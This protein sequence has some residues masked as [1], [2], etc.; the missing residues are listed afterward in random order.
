MN[1]SVGTKNSFV[2]SWLSADRRLVVSA[3]RRLVV[4]SLSFLLSSY[5]SPHLFFVVSFFLLAS[6]ALP[7]CAAKSSAR[8]TL[9]LQ[10]FRNRNTYEETSTEEWSSAFPQPS[11]NAR[12]TLY[13]S[14]QTL[15][16]V[17]LMF[18]IYT[19]LLLLK[20]V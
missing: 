17:L 16:M 4:S 6:R 10:E 5:A 2:K 3:N 9:P 12:A 1:K 13:G 15:E 19:Y 18:P 11:E 8:Q 14:A 20:D 7:G